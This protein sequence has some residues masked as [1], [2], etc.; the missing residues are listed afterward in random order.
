MCVF[1]SVYTSVCVCVLYTCISE[2]VLKCVTFFACTAGD[3]VQS[4]SNS[5]TSQDDGE[6]TPQFN[7]HSDTHHLSSGQLIVKPCSQLI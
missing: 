1:H 2:C 4:P 6:T 5:S 3:I 7:V